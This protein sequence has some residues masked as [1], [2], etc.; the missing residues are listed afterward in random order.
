MSIRIQKAKTAKE[1]VSFLETLA[2]AGGDKRYIFRGHSKE[3]HKLETTLSRLHGGTNSDCTIEFNDKLKNN[4]IADNLEAFRDGI[5][6]NSKIKSPDIEKDNNLDLLAYA[7]HHGLPSPC[8]DFTDS[9]YVAL[10]FAFNGVKVNDSN[11]SKTKYSVVY[12]I[13]IGQ[14]AHAWSKLNLGFDNSFSREQYKEFL[15]E[16]KFKYG[17]PADELM[18]IPNMG[19]DNDRQKAQEGVFLYDTLEYGQPKGQPLAYIKDLE[20][21]LAHQIEPS[22]VPIL[23][24]VFIPHKCAKQ[25]FKK[26]RQENKTGSE[27]YMSAEGV[28]M[29]IINSYNAP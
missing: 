24:K 3:E 26:L 9:P 11:K 22:G 17:F 18:F 21:Y 10:F 20:D 16:K 25:I 4:L 15:K 12:A 13:D 2:L 6:S 7:R 28:A 8:I 5:K 19:K 29:D 14:L 1:A 27:L 23:T